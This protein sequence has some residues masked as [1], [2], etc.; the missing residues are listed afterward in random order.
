VVARS[1]RGSGDEKPRTTTGKAGIGTH[2]ARVAVPV[3]SALAGGR[4]AGADTSLWREERAAME[5]LRLRG[6]TEAKDAAVHLVP[7]PAVEPAS[8]TP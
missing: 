8:R 6:R 7:F 5:K 4:N 3:G 2:T 1:R